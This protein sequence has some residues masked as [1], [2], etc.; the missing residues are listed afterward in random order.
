MILSG[1]DDSTND[2]CKS[3]SII[4]IISPFDVIICILIHCLGTQFRPHHGA[5]PKMYQPGGPCFSG[6]GRCCTAT[7][8]DARCDL[9]TWNSIRWFIKTAM[10][11]ISCIHHFRTNQHFRFKLFRISGMPSAIFQ[12]ETEPDALIS[13]DFFV[14]M[15]PWRHLVK[16]HGAMVPWRRDGRVH[17]IGIQLNVAK[18]I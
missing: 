13:N 16:S 18:N 7:G 15:V 5:K 10:K 12:L 9:K 8:Q 4:N 14:Y 6:R 3:Y 2:H 11:A 1:N 17:P